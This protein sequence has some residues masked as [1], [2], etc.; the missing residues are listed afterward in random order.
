M[1]EITDE[2]I[3]HLKHQ[4]FK[5]KKH[6]KGCACGYCELK[7]WEKQQQQ[8]RKEFSKRIKT[9]KLSEETKEELFRLFKDCW[10]TGF[11]CLYCGRKMDLHFENEYSFTIDH[12]LARSKGGKDISDNLVFCCRDCNLLKGD[13]SVENYL[14]NMERLKLRKKKKEYWKARKATKKDEQ[15]R[16]SYKDIFQMVNAK[17][18]R[19]IK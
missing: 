12:Y 9:L 3:E 16:E 17:K 5:N 13:M 6:E 8:L 14:K 10:N 4:D 18:E 7:R 2:H 1:N 11:E 15:T 19:P